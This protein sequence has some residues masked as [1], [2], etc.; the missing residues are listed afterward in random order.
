MEA[1]VV[2]KKNRFNWF[3]MFWQGFTHMTNYGKTLWVLVI[4]KLIIMFFI[5]KPF[6]FPKYLD[7]KFDSDNEKASYVTTELVE[8][9]LK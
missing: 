8:R 7:E 1:E 9:S 3:I 4:L 5:L 2:P 6:F